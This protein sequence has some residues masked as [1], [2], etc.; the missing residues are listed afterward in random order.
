MCRYR[1][2]RLGFG[3]GGDVLSSGWPY[4]GVRLVLLVIGGYRDSQLFKFVVNHAKEGRSLMW[5]RWGRCGW[6]GVCR[7]SSR[8]LSP[9]TPV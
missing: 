4:R 3:I 6:A 7:W 9:A 2:W 8:M 1:M 5:S